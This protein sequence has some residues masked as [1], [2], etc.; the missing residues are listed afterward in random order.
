MNLHSPILLNSDGQRNHYTRWCT[1][2]WTIQELHQLVK[3]QTIVGNLNPPLFL[4]QIRIVLA[5]LPLDPIRFSMDFNGNY[6]PLTRLDNTRL[7]TLISFGFCNSKAS[8]L[9]SPEPVSIAE[10]PINV[11]RKYRNTVITCFII[12]PETDEKLMEY[13]YGSQILTDSQS[14]N[15][16]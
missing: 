12:E 13:F 5:D 8:N 15:R 3:E 6:K 1:K 11:Q 9:I 16:S 4:D 7:S 2:H 10:L 14:F